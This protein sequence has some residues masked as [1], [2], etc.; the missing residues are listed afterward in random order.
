MPGRMQPYSQAGVVD[1]LGMRISRMLNNRVMRLIAS[2]YV[3]LE[4]T[5][6]SVAFVIWHMEACWSTM[7]MQI[8]IADLMFNYSSYIRTK[9]P[10]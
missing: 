10:E 1:G 4:I 3:L 5:H 6:T 8:R 2:V 7:I 9:W